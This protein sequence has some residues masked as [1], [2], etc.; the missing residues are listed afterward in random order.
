MKWSIKNRRPPGTLFVKLARLIFAEEIVTTVVSAAVADFRHELEHAAVSCSSQFTVRLRWYWALV[1]LVIAVPMSTPTSPVSG[2]AHSVSALNG[3]W[4]LTL[5]VAALYIGT[6]RFFGSFAIAAA[7]VG[8]AVAIVMRT[9]HNQHPSESVEPQWDAAS[10]PVHIN[11]SMIRVPGDGP[12]LVFAA[13]TVLIVVL[14]F[15][16]LWWFF[17][18]AALGSVLVAFGRFNRRSGGLLNSINSR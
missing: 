1:S 3:G 8:V 2:H 11:L 14:A 18:C 10:P 12:G 5:L 7:C 16:E 13:S 17:V 4:L 6:W 15:P 9:W